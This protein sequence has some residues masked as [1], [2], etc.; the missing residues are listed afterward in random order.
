MMKILASEPSRCQSDGV[1]FYP[2]LCQ[3]DPL[4]ENRELYLPFL[5]LF[6]ELSVQGFES[7]LPPLL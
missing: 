7:H 5:V 4:A 6:K 3:R 2:E 1:A